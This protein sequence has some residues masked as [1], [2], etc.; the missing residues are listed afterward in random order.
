MVP[1]PRGTSSGLVSPEE[2][3]EEEVEDI[4]RDKRCWGMQ[5]LNTTTSGELHAPWDPEELALY[6]EPATTWTRF[7]LDTTDVTAG[8]EYCQFQIS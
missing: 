4:M 8:E 2:Q 7:S 3:E 1:P 6:F 5:E